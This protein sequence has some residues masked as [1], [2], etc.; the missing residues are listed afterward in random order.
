MSGRVALGACLSVLLAS[1]SGC[2]GR[3]NDGGVVVRD[4]GGIEIVESLADAWGPGEGWSLSKEPVVSIGRE[5]GPREYLLQRVRAALRLPDGRVLVA[6]G[7]TS[8]LRYFDSSGTYLNT[9]GRYGGGPG[10]FYRIESVWFAGDSLVIF[11]PYQNRISVLSLSGELGRT[12]TIGRGPLSQPFSVWAFA[13]GRILAGMLVI[14]GGAAGL[15]RERIRLVYRRYAPNGTALDSLGVFPQWEVYSESHSLGAGQSAAVATSAPFG[16]QS[17]TCVSGDR[18]YYASS[19]SYDMQVFDSAGRLERIIRRPVPNRPV[20]S[21]DVEA[22]KAE[23]LDGESPGSWRRRIVDELT[24]PETMPAYGPVVVDAL[25]NAWVAE[26][27][28]EGRID[29]KG[30]WTVF[31][32]NGRMLGVVEMPTGGRVTT[33]GADYV[34]GVWTSEQDV[35][36]VRMYR[37]F[38]Q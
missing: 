25:G 9:V 17:S 38:R 31:D 18:L 1:V 26:Y 20:T 6:D 15:R 24:F 29:R 4:S 10:E 36:Q 19:E 13:D 27:S 3:R 21:R 14:D 16:R 11:D 23:F 8:E 35:P 7:G 32:P 33:I 22:F 28:G 12:L 37:L 30:R 5:D 34:M 2:A